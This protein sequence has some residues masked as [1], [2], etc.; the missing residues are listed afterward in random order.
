MLH[1]A[2]SSRGL[3]IKSKQ[4]TVSAE[5]IEVNSNGAKLG[6]IIKFKR[7]LVIEKMTRFRLAKLAH[8]I[9]MLLSGPLYENEN[10]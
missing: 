2:S 3:G 5:K 4:N 7:H 8:K 10:L 9:C 1:L 6:T